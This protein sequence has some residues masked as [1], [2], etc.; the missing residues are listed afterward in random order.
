MATDRAVGAYARSVTETI[1]DWVSNDIRSIQ[2]R[3][4]ENTQLWYYPQVSLGNVRVL[5]EDGVST[6]ITA[7]QAF[8]VKF[9]LTRIGYDNV[10]LRSE[11]S[12]TAVSVINDVL[13]RRPSR[14]P[15][16]PDESKI[17]WGGR[18]GC[19]GERPGGDNNYE[20]LSLQDDSTRLGIRKRLEVLPNGDLTVQDDVTVEFVRHRS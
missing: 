5:V 7:D 1:V 14:W 10:E 20:M 19:G 6:G 12:K 11:L 9:Y 13:G 4:L 18:V 15:P 16:C 8:R 3:L 17:A 2:N